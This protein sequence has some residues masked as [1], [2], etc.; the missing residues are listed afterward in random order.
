[1][2]SAGDSRTVGGDPVLEPVVEAS[3]AFSYGSVTNFVNRHFRTA[4]LGF[5]GPQ[6]MTMLK[7]I[8]LNAQLAPDA[9]AAPLIAAVPQRGA[10]DTALRLFHS[11]NAADWLAPVARLRRQ[12]LTGEAL[13]GAFMDDN[14]QPLSFIQV[15]FGTYDRGPVARRRFPVAAPSLLFPM[16]TRLY[17]WSNYDEP[18]PD[19]RRSSDGGPYTSPASEATDVQD[20]ARVLHSAP[21]DFLEAYFPTR[22]ITDVNFAQA[23]SRAGDLRHIR[24]IDAPRTRPRLTIH[25]GDSGLGKNDPPRPSIGGAANVHVTLP[26]YNHNDVI[27][28]APV[29][30][31]G[32]PEPTAT[33]VARF[34][35]DQAGPAATTRVVPR[36]GRAT[37]AVV[38]RRLRDAV[39]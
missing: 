13:L 29:T 15:S 16:D 38:T 7:T 8:G 22:I 14:S 23:G 25:A 9:D 36:T 1:M 6:T 32:A 4:D 3:G 20:L 30:N 31:T 33:A 28:A 35:L 27:T 2:V 39:R 24:Y 10:A 17:G 34:L 37:D 21:L 19:L 26:G 11:E 18:L 12:H 5:I